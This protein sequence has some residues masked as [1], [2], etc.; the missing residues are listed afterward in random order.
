MV[1]LGGVAKFLKRLIYI[2]VFISFIPRFFFQLPKD[3]S[4]LAVAAVHGL[5]Y[6]LAYVLIEMLF[7][8]KR[9]GKCLATD[10]V[11]SV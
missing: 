4:K 9:I 2:F 11:A 7:N 3:G 5:L 8:L 6:A 10:G 1:S